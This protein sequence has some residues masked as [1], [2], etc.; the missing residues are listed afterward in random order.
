MSDRDSVN[1]HLDRW[2]PVM[3]DLDPVIEGAVTRMQFLVMH[4]RK[5]R[6]Q[7]LVDHELHL[8]E[9]STLKA[10]AARGGEATPSELAAD[11]K[12]SPATMSGRLETLE[13]RGFL[14]RDM[15][16]V[17]RRKVTVALTASGRRKWRAAMDVQGEEEHRLMARL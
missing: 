14:R 13:Q 6:E 12:V 9:F 3:P 7:S 10:L 17:D 16:T 4:L 15:S 5:V 2:L 11:L 1:D 8:Y